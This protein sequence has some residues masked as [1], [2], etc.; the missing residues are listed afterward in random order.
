MVAKPDISISAE[1]PKAD[2]LGQFW[3]PGKVLLK[4]PGGDEL[5]APSIV[6]SLVAPVRG[7]MTLDDLR[8]AQIQA[9]HDILTAAL[10]SLESAPKET[11]NEISAGTA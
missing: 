4:W 2:K 6:I 11:V 3:S 5:P 10:L 7:D 1:E 8:A 9:A